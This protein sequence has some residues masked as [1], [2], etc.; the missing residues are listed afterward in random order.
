MGGSVGQMGLGQAIAA[1]TMNKVNQNP[2]FAAMMDTLNR[3]GQARTSV[4][5]NGGAMNTVSF[6]PGNQPKLAQ[7]GKDLQASGVDIGI[8][9]FEVTPQTMKRREAISTIES[10]GN[11]QALGP[12]THG[13]RALGKYQIMDYNVGPWSVEALGKRLTPEQFLA[14]PKAQD[15]IFDHKFTNY[16]NQFGEQ[17]AAQ[18]WLGGPGS[19]GKGSRADSLGTTVD[20]YGQR[21]M[22]LLGQ[23]GSGEQKPG[24]MSALGQ[25]LAAMQAGDNQVGGNLVTPDNIAGYANGETTPQ[26]PLQK[27]IAAA[28]AHSHP[29]PQ[30]QAEAPQVAPVQ[31]KA[32]QAVAT[33]NQALPTLQAGANST[34]DERRQALQQK[35]RYQNV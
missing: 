3:T 6:L 14:D 25:V 16:V 5:G 21:Y 7:L 30:A 22:S 9:G 26:T 33:I 1:G 17:G 34:A 29:Q 15:A 4:T 10:G 8:P 18:A 23:G 19:V 31:D 11:Y 2:I 27:A 20:S 32:K 12:E 28:A 13:G 35:I 24:K